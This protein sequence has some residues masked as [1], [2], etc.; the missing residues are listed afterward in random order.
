MSRQ[1]SGGRLSSSCIGNLED[2]AIEYIEEVEALLQQDSDLAQLIAYNRVRE[3]VGAEKLTLESI[4]RA[5]ELIEQDIRVFEELIA[6][7]GEI[8]ED[9]QTLAGTR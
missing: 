6:N 1:I 3:L 4:E 2:E 7:G 5:G 8:H 9:V